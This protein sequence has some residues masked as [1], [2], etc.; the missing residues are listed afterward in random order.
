MFAPKS[1]LE[2]KWLEQCFFR[3]KMISITYQIAQELIK[4]A[5]HQANSSAMVATLMS[6]IKWILGAVAASMPSA[7][8]RNFVA[9]SD[10]P[11]CI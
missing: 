3:L 10:F 6:N 11:F 8:A 4:N 9:L 5:L 7:S 1:T 2:W